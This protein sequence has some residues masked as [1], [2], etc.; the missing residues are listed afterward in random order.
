MNQ[1]LLDALSLIG[2]KEIVILRQGQRIAALERRIVELEA[3]KKDLEEQVKAWDEGAK[4]IQ[5]GTKTTKKIN[6]EEGAEDNAV[7]G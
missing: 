7:Q 6:P 5:P 1:D 4:L 3:Q 2:E